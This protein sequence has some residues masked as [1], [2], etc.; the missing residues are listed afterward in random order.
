MR[1]LGNS[2]GMAENPRV[3]SSILCLGIPKKIIRKRG[4][5]ISRSALFLWNQRLWPDLF[6]S[7][8]I[9]AILTDSY[10]TGMSV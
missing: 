3:H 1:K 6:G 7:S 5:P 4:W 8:E 10:I 9:K 2:G